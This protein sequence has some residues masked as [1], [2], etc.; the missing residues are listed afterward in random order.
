MTTCKVAVR[1]SV[2]MCRSIAFGRFFEPC[3]NVDIALAN[4]GVTGAAAVALRLMSASFMKPPQGSVIF[5][6]GYDYASSHS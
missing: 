3:I 6:S 4:Q 2:V 1:L 5:E